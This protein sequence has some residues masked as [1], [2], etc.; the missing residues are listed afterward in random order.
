MATKQEVGRALAATMPL[1]ANYKPPRPD[2]D[3]RGSQEMD[4]LVAAWL[5]MVGHL[6]A[7]TFQA[8]LQ[9]VAT[10]SE[11]FPTPALVLAAAQELT[12]APQRTG[13]DAW[14]DVVAAIAKHGVYHPPGGVQVLAVA[15]DVWDFDDPI[16]AKLV[17]AFGWRD[18]CMSENAVADR[19]RFIPAYEQEQQREREQARLTPALAAFQ[20]EQ[21]AALPAP[22]ERRQAAARLM[23]G[24]GRREQG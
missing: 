2:P 13:A 5:P 16:V 24:I 11:F 9:L 19:A 23:A 22:A 20:A 21:R 3:G 15:G 4:A 7:A 18:L 1:F 14:G 12:T 10:R 6:D 17:R 8:A